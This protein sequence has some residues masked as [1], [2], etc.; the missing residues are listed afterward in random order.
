MVTT[1]TTSETSVGTAH[2]LRQVTRL[3]DSA[4][5]FEQGGTAR[6]T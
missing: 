3:R 1:F 4:S 5:P 6:A 2:A